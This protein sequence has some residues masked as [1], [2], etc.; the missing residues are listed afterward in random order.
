[1]QACSLERK[2]ECKK[3]DLTPIAPIA[4]DPANKVIELT[5]SKSKIVFK[6]LPP[7]DPIQ[8]KPDIRLAKEHLGWELEIPIEEGLKQTI[9]YFE[10]LISSL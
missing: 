9:T 1:M 3:Q 7:D 5:G 4:I 10:R 2:E 8:R 6:L